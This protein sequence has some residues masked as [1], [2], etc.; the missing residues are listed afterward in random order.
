MNDVKIVAWK[1]EGKALIIA[2]EDYLFKQEVEEEV[3]HLKEIKG[4]DEEDK[5]LFRKSEMV[6]AEQEVEV[7]TSEADDEV[8]SITMTVSV[9]WS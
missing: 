2:M 4:G 8:S 1:T 7:D 3:Q 5:E 9:S 6:E